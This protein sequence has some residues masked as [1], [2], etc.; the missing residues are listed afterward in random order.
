M[1]LPD[2]RP[3]FAPP[4]LFMKWHQRG[5]LLKIV[6]CDPKRKLKEILPG[7]FLPR[8]AGQPL[9]WWAHTY[10]FP[11]YGE[12]WREHL[13][14]C[15]SPWEW[16]PDAWGGGHTEFSR[17]HTGSH[18]HIPYLHAQW[19]LVPGLYLPEPRC[20]HIQDDIYYSQDSVGLTDHAC[21][22]H[23]PGPGTQQVL[24]HGSNNYQCSWTWVPVLTNSSTG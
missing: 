10:L 3:I 9:C 6:P 11:S 13:Q 24:N 17:E 18:F 20:L 1:S 5:F 19:D 23:N 22:P 14:M 15:W 4:G 16:G 12:V 2:L 21:K 7:V 8:G